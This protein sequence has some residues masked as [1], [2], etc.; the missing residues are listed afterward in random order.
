M[1]KHMDKESQKTTIWPTDTLRLRENDW[2]P[3]IWA[4]ALTVLKT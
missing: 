3:Q 1:N 2:R 4:Q